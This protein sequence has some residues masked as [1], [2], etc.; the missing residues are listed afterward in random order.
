MIITATMLFG[1]E[2][3]VKDEMRSLG[4]DMSAAVVSDGRIDVRM[5]DSE[6]CS[7][8]ARLNMNLRTAE[9]ILLRFGGNHAESFDDLF[10]AALLVPWEE[11]IPKGWAFHVN[12]H[13]LKSKL[14]GISA[15]Q[16]VIKKAIVKRLIR[17]YGYADSADV[18]EDPN[19]GLMKIVF[20][21][22][23]D[24][25]SFMADTSGDGLHKRGYR[26]LT[27][28]APLK[29]TL[30]AGLVLLSMW[31][32]DN[33][34]VLL[35]PMCGTGT[36]AVEA[37]LIASETA[38][39]L[40]RGF[41]AEKWS[42]G[43]LKA[44]MAAREEAMDRRRVLPARKPEMILGSDIDPSSISAAMKNSESAGVSKLIGYSVRDALSY[45]PTAIRSATESDKVLIITNPPYGER[46]LDADKASA[47][48]S[49]LGEKWLWSGSVI[50]GLRLSIIA[51][52]DNFENDFGGFADKRRKLYNGKIQCNMY[53]YFKSGRKQ[54]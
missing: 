29:E 51:P 44:F 49:G 13:S 38:P 4:I 23:R 7:Q 53:H 37:A 17:A 26:P 41:A 14:F 48:F 1:L 31:R 28:T 34:E 10:E 6:V 50:P 42:D 21:I 5:P 40:N 3:T 43:Y 35:D 2:S 27:H 19:K 15:C 18:P 36:I 32:Y 52:K 45:D 8:V 25:V 16:S 47:L 12:G 11:H 33:G 9:R 20:S 24:E 39:G 22:V 54:K 46:M 30:A